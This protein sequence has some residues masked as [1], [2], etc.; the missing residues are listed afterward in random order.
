M[1]TVAIQNI[2]ITCCLTCC[3][4]LGYKPLM[5]ALQN[6]VLLL[7]HMNGRKSETLLGGSS[8]L[9]SDDKQS[10]Q[11]RSRNPSLSSEATVMNSDQSVISEETPPS[12]TAGD[13]TES[14]EDYLHDPVE[15][16]QQPSPQPPQCVIC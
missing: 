7:S 10:E 16:R 5:L 4:S 9:I 12:C 1:K 14:S 6:Q 8:S 3:F 15:D 11:Q 2:Q 13:V